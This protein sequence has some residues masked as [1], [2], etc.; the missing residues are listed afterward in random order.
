MPQKKKGKRKS[1]AEHWQR[2]T[3]SI[4]FKLIELDLQNLKLDNLICPTEESKGPEIFWCGKGG[5]RKKEETI[6]SC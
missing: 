6:L 1:P 2:G 3:A 5:K 4:S